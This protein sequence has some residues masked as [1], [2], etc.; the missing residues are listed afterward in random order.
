MLQAIF[1]AT[2]FALASMIPACAQGGGPGHPEPLREFVMAKSGETVR[3]WTFVD[4]EDPRASPG[5]FG[6]AAN[7]LIVVRR[8]TELQCG[9]P[10]Q[11]VAQVFYA[12]REGFFGDDD[13]VVRGPRGQEV[14]IK[15]RVNPSV[16]I[17]GAPPAQAAAAREPQTKKATPPERIAAPQRAASR[18]HV[19]AAG[20]SSCPRK[21]GE[22]TIVR[23]FRCEFAASKVGNRRRIVGAAP[24]SAR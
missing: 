3:V 17:A 10:E 21:R 16:E 6:T 18:P 19:K 4:C 2:L 1:V 9:N 24:D 5:A 22:A 7:G 8:G 12:A 11:P 15:I 23:L 20:V 13:A 14:L